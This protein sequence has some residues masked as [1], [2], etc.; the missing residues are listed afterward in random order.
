MS[1]LDIT[2]CVP[3][4]PVRRKLLDRAL[5]SVHAQVLQPRGIAIAIDSSKRGAANTRNRA[6]EMA[7]TEWV[8]FLDDDDEMMH[9]HLA[10]CADVQAETGADVIVPWY[11]VVGGTDPVP[12]HRHLQIDPLRLHSIAITCLVRREA[13][14]SI[15]FLEREETGMPEDFLFWTQLGQAGATFHQIPDTTWLWHHHGANTSGMG[16]RW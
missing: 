12:G 1:A 15:R 5:N 2:V 7:T 13:I 9:H 10:R 11:N 4:I 14:G 16:S 3:T 8:A 6:L